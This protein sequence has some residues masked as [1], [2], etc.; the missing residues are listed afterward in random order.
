[1][2]SSFAKKVFWSVIFGL[3][4]HFRNYNLLGKFARFWLRFQKKKKK[5]HV[6]LFPLVSLTIFE[7]SWQSYS[8]KVNVSRIFR[9]SGLGRLP[10]AGATGVG[11]NTRLVLCR[12]QCPERVSWAPSKDGGEVRQPHSFCRPEAQSAVLGTT[13]TGQRATSSLR[14]KTFLKRSRSC[15]VC[16]PCPV[17]LLSCPSCPTSQH[18]LGVEISFPETSLVRCCGRWCPNVQNRKSSCLLSLSSTWR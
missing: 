2:V 11:G 7:G 14:G 12:G 5:C 18:S 9:K 1:M 17:F 4:V 3:C 10:V 6:F 8:L 16:S 13:A 15:Y